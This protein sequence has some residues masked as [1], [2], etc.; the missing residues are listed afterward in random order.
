[1]TATWSK[2]GMNRRYPYYACSKHCPGIGIRAEELER[3]FLEILDRF[4]MKPELVALFQKTIRDAWLSN[5]E[6]FQQIAAVSCRRLIELERQR[7][8]LLEA[9]VYKQAIKEEH[10]RQESERLETEIASA[11]IEATVAGEQIDVNAVVD[12]AGELLLSAAEFWRRSSLEQKQR[13]QKVLLPQAITVGADKEVRTDATCS[14]Y[15]ILQIVEA[16]NATTPCRRCASWNG[17]MD[18][19]RQIDQFRQ[20]L[21]E[22]PAAA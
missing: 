17:I 14:S 15:S 16:Q 2:G 13:L 8:C 10:Y 9:F 19:L 1:M 6:G 5:Q 12:F 22:L 3:K 4:R 7:Q 21:N 18:W 11:K 20:S